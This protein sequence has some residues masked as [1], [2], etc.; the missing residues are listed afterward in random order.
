MED[1][2]GQLLKKHPA[3]KKENLIIILQELQ[4]ARGHLS[5]EDIQKVSDYLDIPVNKVYGVATFYDQFRFKPAK[6]NNAAPCTKKRISYAFSKEDKAFLFDNVL[7]TTP[8]QISKEE[9]E[10]LLYFRRDK[11]NKTVIYI[12]TGSCGTSSG[13]SRWA[14][15]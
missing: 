8:E 11:V 14:C 9:Q 1:H 2:I 13:A 10:K 6:D 15:R 12:G 4:N 5:K 7:K 3:N